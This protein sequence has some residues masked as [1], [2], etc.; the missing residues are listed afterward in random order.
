MPTKTAHRPHRPARP[1]RRR[2]AHRAS[3]PPPQR[4]VPRILLRAAVISV[5]AGVLLL[6]LLCAALLMT[7]DPGAYA[8][9]AA[10]LLPLPAALLCGIL[11]S[12]GAP[13]RGLLRGLGGGVLF[14]LLLCGMGLLC[15][16]NGG[17]AGLHI[18][19][20][21]PHLPLRAAACVLLSGIGGYAAARR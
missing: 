16:R 15:A 11:S 17:T 4:A 2:R 7:E 14:C 3:V 20:L 10:M 12:H 18:S 8:E 21:L 19:P 1:H 5:G 6:L 9:T 13:S